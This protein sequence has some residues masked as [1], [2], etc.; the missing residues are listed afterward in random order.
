MIKTAYDMGVPRARKL[1]DVASV[2][3][4]SGTVTPLDMATAYAPLSN[5]GFRIAPL[6]IRKIVK[7]DGTVNAF[8]PERDEVFSDGVAYEVTR[9]LEDNVTSGTGTGAQIGVPVA[10]KTGTTD[11]YVDAWFVGLHAAV[12]HRGLGGLPQ[13]RRACGAP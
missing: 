11:D 5:G 7:P 6:A 12:L 4:G 8:A 9:I 10:G 1:P 2:G 3:L 13:Q